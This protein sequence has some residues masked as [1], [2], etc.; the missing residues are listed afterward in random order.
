MARCSAAKATGNPETNFMVCAFPR[1]VFWIDADPG[2]YVGPRRTKQSGRVR[3]PAN[4]AYC[5]YVS[6]RVSQCREI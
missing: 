3:D 4:S 6:I 2:I 5:L 1:Y